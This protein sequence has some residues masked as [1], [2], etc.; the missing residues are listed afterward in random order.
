MIRQKNYVF[1]KQKTADVF[2]DS[3]RLPPMRGPFSVYA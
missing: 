3:L 1:I 2:F